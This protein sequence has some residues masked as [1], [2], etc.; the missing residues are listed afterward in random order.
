MLDGESVPTQVDTLD[1]GIPG[2]QSYGTLLVVPA[3]ATLETDFHFALPSRVILEGADHKTLV[4]ALRVQKQP[5]TLAIPIAICV[6]LPAGAALVSSSP[7][8]NLE[9][10]N[11][12]LNTNLR[13][14]IQARLEFTIP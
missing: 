4:Y 8:G 11:W 1:E 6:R 3:G 12:C 7:E 2:V 9:G 13:T 5:G 10:E 14:D